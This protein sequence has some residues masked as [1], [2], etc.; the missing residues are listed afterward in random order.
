MLVVHRAA[1][2]TALAAAL[3]DVLASP[4]A[5]PFDS[6]VV[7]VPA[8]GVERWLAQRLAHV[9]GAS[10]GDGVCANVQFPSPVRLLDD[11]V[12]AAWP[13]HAE[14]VERWTPRRSMWRT[15]RRHRRMLG[16]AVVPH[17]GPAPGRRRAPTAAGASSWRSASPACSTTT[18][19]RGPRCC[20]VGPPATTSAATAPARRRPALA[21]RAVAP[22]ARPARRHR[23]RPSCSTTPAPGCARNPSLTALPERMSVF[24]ASRISPARLAVL[25]ALADTATSTSGCT[26]R[27]RRCG[28]R[29]WP[30]RRRSGAQTTAPAPRCATRCSPRSRATCWSSSSCSAGLSRVSRPAARR[31]DRVRTRCSAGSSVTS[32]TT[33]CPTPVPPCAGRPQRAGP[34]VPR[35]YP[36]GRGAARRPCSACS[37]PTRRS[38][39]ATCSSCARTSR[40]S[41]RSIAA[42]FSLG[43]EEDAAHPAA[44]ACASGSPTAPCGR[45]TRCSPC[46]GSCSSSAPPASPRPR[47]STWPAP[48]RCGSGSGSTTTRSSGCATGWP[49][50]GVRWGLDAEH[51]G[52]WQLGE[53]EQGTWRGR[54]RP[55]AARCRDG[56]RR[57]P[58][59]SARRS[60]AAR[61]TTSTAPT[62]TSP[63]ASP[64]WSTGSTR[65]CTTCMLRP[66][67]A[68]RS[69]W[70]ASSTRCSSLAAPPREPRGRRSQLRGELADVAEAAAGTER[71]ARPRRRARA[72]RAHARR[73]ADPGQL[74]HRHADRLHARADALGPAPG[75]VPARPRR[76]RLPAAE[77][78]DGD[79]VLA[80]DPWVGERDPRSEDRQL[81]LDAMLRRGRAPRRHLHRRRRAHRCAACRRAVP[82]GELLD[83]LDRTAT[84][85][86]RHAGCATSSPRTTRCSRSTARNFAPGALDCRG[87]FSFDPLG[88][89]GAQA[90]RAS[91]SD[92]AP[93][94][95][96]AAAAAD[97]SATSSSPTCSRLLEHPARGFLRQRLEVAVT[98]ERGGAGRRA[99]RRARL[100]AAVGDRRP[101]AAR[102]GRRDR[103]GRV[104]SSSSGGAACCRPVRSARDRGLDRAR[105]G[106]GRCAASVL[107]RE[108]PPGTHRRRRAAGRRHAAD[109]HRPGVRGRRAALPTYSSL[110][111]K[112]RLRAWVELLALTASRPPRGGARSPS[113]RRLPGAARSVLAAGLRRRAAGARSSWSRLP[114]AVCGRRCRCR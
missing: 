63:A 71:A 70:P 25:A 22:A 18:P 56:G 30:P 6:E 47:C 101:G 83:A 20:G 11:A 50:A 32:R 86:R 96:L 42:A 94:L 59:P 14:A 26:T 2:G 80:R 77:H 53:L 3:A 98:R 35:A 64:S 54:S 109:R 43:A 12:Q 82:L 38:S 62:S 73:P 111:P 110:G 45:P 61:S 99:A 28:T 104:H 15:A 97:R 106:G 5:D 44:R 41:R 102:P 24:G 112:H 87:P 103:A 16:R 81:L 46:S 76:R 34:R 7:A 74:P 100:A 29:G 8:K 40:R 107:E 1:E 66:A 19:S 33:R 49:R 37:P 68:R 75:G 9:L 93:F 89:A 51:R 21:G 17:A 60:A 90:A 108:T 4:S 48:T 36:A 65:P 92:A 69:G 31:G 85:R 105:G 58:G 114:R 27:P 91:A 23:H 67:H 79:D 39:R 95:V 113:V 52:R 55:A 13:E 72:A 84:D 88:V 10:T 57:T 78:R